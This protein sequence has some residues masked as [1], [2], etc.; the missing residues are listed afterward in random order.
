[1]ILALDA[2]ENH[3]SHD[4]QDITDAMTRAEVTDSVNT[5]IPETKDSVPPVTAETARRFME[6]SDHHSQYASG[7]IPLI[8]EDAPE[9]AANLLNSP[10]DY[11]IIVDKSSMN[12]LLFDRYGHEVEAYKMACAKNYGTKHARRDSRTPEGYFT[13]AGI[14][15]ST[16]WLFT[17]DDGN[18]S[19]VKG[20]FGPRFIRLKTPVSSQ[21]GIH[22]TCAPWSLGGRRSH[23]CIRLANENI[24]K[25]VEYAKK[26]MP[27]IVNPGPKDVRVNESEGYHIPVIR[28]GHEHH[29]HV[30]KDTVSSEHIGDTTAED[31]APAASRPDTTSYLPTS[32]KNVELV[33]E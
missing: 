2:C 31:T 24:L 15:D 27:V 25:L 26:G 11:F 23:G 13:I 14:F 30:Q 22:G 7:I 8:L 32:D 28:T 20:Q 19:E 18:T 5:A 17:D 33:K 16:D 6:Q 4:I 10:F 1:M 9:Y 12:V 3:H 29:P 21:I